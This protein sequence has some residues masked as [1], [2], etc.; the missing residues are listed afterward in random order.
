MDEEGQRDRERKTQRGWL[1]RGL[2]RVSTDAI[3]GLAFELESSSIHVC[4]DADLKATQAVAHH[5]SPPFIC[6][7]P[8]N[9]PPASPFSKHPTIVTFFTPIDYRSLPF[10]SHFL[11]F[12]FFFFVLHPPGH[13]NLFGV[14]PLILV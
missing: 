11:Y 3:V 6:P 1:Q 7:T 13:R 10:Q 2:Q 9:H 14:P 12:L 4:F 5:V 8:G